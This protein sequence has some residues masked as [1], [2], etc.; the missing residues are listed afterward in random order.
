M[1]GIAFDKYLFVLEELKMI[2]YKE[3]LEKTDFKDMKLDVSF[4]APAEAVEI[5]GNKLGLLYFACRMMEFV[6]EDCA[7]D[8]HAE[9]NFAPGI[10]LEGRLSLCVFKTDKW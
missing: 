7:E 2:D 4:S 8:E 3:V 6:E 9:Y 5:F 10:D 1:N